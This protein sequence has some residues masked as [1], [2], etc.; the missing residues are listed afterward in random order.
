MLYDSYRGSYKNQQM[1]P[2]KKSY[3]RTKK[4]IIGASIVLLLVV[5][6]LLYVYAFNGNLF[7]WSISPHTTN[8]VIKTSPPPQITPSVTPATGASK[9]SD[10]TGTTTPKDTSQIPV[11]TTST[12][13]ITQLSEDANNVTATAAIANASQSGTCSFV[14]TNPYNKP[15]TLQ[16]SAVNSSCGP[17]SVPNNA[18][19]SVGDWKLTV[20]YFYQNTQATAEQ[21]I[22]IK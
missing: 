2:L 15:I 18:F 22:K 19:P 5:S 10:Q 21:V 8:P 17:V 14:F 16:S 7:G 3:S 12:V 1:L 6:S 4:I 20:S 13:T 9:G 11:S